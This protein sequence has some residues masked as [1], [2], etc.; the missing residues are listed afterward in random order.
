MLTRSKRIHEV[1]NQGATPLALEALLLFALPLLFT[2]QKL[3]VLPLLG[4]IEYNHWLPLILSKIYSL[5]ES[6]SFSCS[7]SGS[8]A[9][10]KGQRFAL[11][12]RRENAC[13][14][15]PYGVRQNRLRQAENNRHFL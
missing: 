9:K 13:K 6:S 12:P 8:S 4:D 5:D 2:L 1:R 3:V 11:C 14:N 15:E 10:G 7:S